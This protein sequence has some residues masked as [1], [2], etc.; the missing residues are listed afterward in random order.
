M[1]SGANQPRREF[2][3]HY[4]KIES[5]EYNTPPGQMLNLPAGQGLKLYWGTLGEA[6]LGAGVWVRHSDMQSK[7]QILF[8]SSE[9][10][11]LNVFVRHQ[12]MDLFVTLASALSKYDLKAPTGTEAIYDNSGPVTLSSACGL[13]SV[14]LP[15]SWLC[16]PEFRSERSQSVSGARQTT[17]RSGTS[18]SVQTTRAEG[19]QWRNHK[20]DTL[21]QSISDLVSLSLA[22]VSSLGTVASAYTVVFIS[23]GTQR[24]QFGK[25]HRA[26]FQVD[27]GFIYTVDT[28]FSRPTPV[29]HFKRP[30]QQFITRSDCLPLTVSELPPRV[31]GVTFTA[32][33][34]GGRFWGTSDNLQLSP[35]MYSFPSAHRACIRIVFGYRAPFLTWATTLC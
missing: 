2:F 8:R 11:G 24:F 20:A 1:A 9:R 34:S 16:W 22:A 28:V 31:P 13:W 3:K 25:F 26:V 19:G 17:R 12:D 23:L 18:G 7:Y 5:T 21:N 27:V 10:V 33:R 6:S 32:P 4:I 15:P 29:C 30:W 35:V 14:Y